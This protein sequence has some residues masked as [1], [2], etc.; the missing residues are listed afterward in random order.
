MARLG[1]F[2]IPTSH[3][4]DTKMNPPNND[5]PPLKNIEKSG[6][7][8]MKLIKPKDDKML[9]RFKVNKKGYASC[10]LFFVDGDG[11]CLT[12]NYS[13]EFGKGL[14]MLVGKMTGTF[15]PEAPTSITVDNL[16]RYVSPA[17]GKR[18]TIEIEATEDKEWNGKMQ[19]NYKLKK[20]TP[21]DP[22]V[23]GAKSADDIPESFTSGAD[24]QVPF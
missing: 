1:P 11:N 18:A 22:A 23:Y 2:T 5:L 17:F 19:Y 20:I 9:E 6:T 14:A 15:T 8:V 7:Y 13:V 4:P 10:R 16:I 12:K 24:E 3:Q 21:V